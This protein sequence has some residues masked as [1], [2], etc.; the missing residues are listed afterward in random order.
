MQVYNIRS[1]L[2]PVLVE[3]RRCEDKRVG[4]SGRDLI[5]RGTSAYAEN[6]GDVVRYLEDPPASA[7]VAE[8]SGRSS[9]RRDTGVPLHIQLA[10]RLRD[11]I[12][13]GALKPGDQLPTEKDLVARYGLSS[14]TVR[15]AVL[16]LAAEGRLYRRA[17]K[18]TFVNAPSIW[19]D[20]LSFSGFSEEMLAAGHQPGSVLIR[21]RFVKATLSTERLMGDTQQS[22]QV[23]EVARVRTNDGVAVAVEEVYYPAWIGEELARRDLRDVSL[24]SLLEEEFGLRLTRA[25]QT[26][27]AMS[28]G[29]RLARLLE[30]RRGSPLLRIERTAYLE[31][32]RLCHGSRAFFRSDRYSYRG[33][34]TRR[35]P[36]GPPVAATAAIVTPE[37]TPTG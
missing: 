6:G 7:G 10:Q 21:A 33:W 29:A 17:G 22:S 18:G 31:D 15:Q 4:V 12:A 3:R 16:T 37:T 19:R 5:D 36:E 13:S 2:H 14:S 35:R 26:I 32:G 30:V 1:R 23:F 34:I 9:L 8:L 24:T 27:A 25:L 11:E 28:A 20:P